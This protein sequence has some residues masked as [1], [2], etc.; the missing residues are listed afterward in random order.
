MAI[1][2]LQ[3]PEP[4]GALRHMPAAVSIEPSAA[5]TDL[6]GSLMEFRSDFAGF[7]ALRQ[8][9]RSGLSEIMRILPEAK[10]V[11][12]APSLPTPSTAQ[13]LAQT[14]RLAASAAASGGAIDNRNV[15]AF[16]GAAS[17]PLAGIS[18]ARGRSPLV[19]SCLC[20]EP[21]ES[22]RG[23][24][25]LRMSASSQAGSDDESDPDMPELIHATPRSASGCDSPATELASAR[26]A[27]SSSDSE[28]ESESPAVNDLGSCWGRKALMSALKG[29]GDSGDCSSA[30][31]DFSGSGQILDLSGPGGGT[32]NESVEERL[33]D[34]VA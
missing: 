22:D 11:A 2:N 5:L 33:D 6:R 24:V 12:P 8:R 17:A 7:Q 30:S 13:R 10:K 18:G 1:Y 16:L 26:S 4:Q 14:P 28:S 34:S 27:C 3:C 23:L 20:T 15:Q 19:S 29:M 25:G 31:V 32:L 21:G 9:R